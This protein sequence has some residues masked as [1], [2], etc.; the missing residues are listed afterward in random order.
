MMRV[1]GREKL[2][3]KGS[4]LKFRSWSFDVLL[5][6]SYEPLNELMNLQDKPLL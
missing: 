1:K 4:R 5:I 2:E 6:T 3:K